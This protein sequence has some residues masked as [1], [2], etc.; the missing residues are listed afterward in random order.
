MNKDVK[1]IREGLVKC[2]TTGGHIM[3]NTLKYIEQLRHKY[4]PMPVRLK[5]N[6]KVIEKLVGEKDWGTITNIIVKAR[7]EN[8]QDFMRIL[9]ELKVSKKN[10]AFFLKMRFFSELNSKTGVLDDFL[11]EDPEFGKIVSTDRLVITEQ[12]TD[13]YTKLFRGESGKLRLKLVGRGEVYQ[14]TREDVKAGLY[15]LNLNKATSWDFIP[16]K[17][18][19]GFEKNETLVDGITQ[20]LNE[21]N[22]CDII[23]HHISTG[24]LLCLNKNKPEPGTIDSIRPITIT[25]ILS[26]L[27]E[28]PLLMELKKVE[29]SEYQL[30]FRE[31]LC[32]ELN[33]M[34][35][36]DRV[37]KLKTQD[38]ANASKAIKERYALFVDLRQAF[39]S[40]NHQIL[41]DKLLKKNVPIEV[42][43]SLIKQMNSTYMPVDLIN[44]INVN[45]GVGQ[46][47][48][49]SPTLF[50][51]YIDD[52]LDLL[53]GL[54]NTV[55][56]FADDTCFIMK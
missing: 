29:L 36:I 43:N 34:R 5:S 27:L 24:R 32:T 19:E 22:S 2:L 44:F 39:D 30:G 49:C 17:A 55:L 13:K 25:G 3:C 51:I 35:L 56:A 45:R 9:Q 54:V 28:Y 1:E 11:I 26:K 47:K 46:G 37:D 40:V 8:Y 10:M 23:P 50:N 14:Y 6:Y 53:S 21:L 12:V 15:R 31:R 48:L 7:N 38:R 18:Y 16:G 42:I 52:L 4:K 41:V 20:L 33:I